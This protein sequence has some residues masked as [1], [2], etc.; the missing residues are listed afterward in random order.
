[1]FEHIEEKEAVKTAALIEVNGYMFYKLL[2]EKTA[3]REAKA[4]LK[5]LADDEKR[6]LKLIETKFFPEAGFRDQITEEE[7]EIEDY[8][9]KEGRAD[10]FSRRINVD[11]LVRSLDDP[12]KALLLAL[13]TEKHSVRYFESLAAYSQTE[14]GRRM[15]N[16]LADE[17]RS[18]VSQIEAMLADGSGH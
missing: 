16:E 9:E 10:M 15:Y 6:H 2:A 8:I 13:E 3:N 18:H 1:M 4:I 17:E 12:R 5:K 7:I 11:E 14:D